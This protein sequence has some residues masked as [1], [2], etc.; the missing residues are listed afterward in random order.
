MDFAPDRHMRIAC[1]GRA[2]E[3][4]HLFEALRLRFAHR[5]G[6]HAGEAEVADGITVHPGLGHTP[7]LRFVRVRT[8]RGWLVLASDAGHTTKRASDPRAPP[9]WSSTW[10]ARWTRSAP[11]GGCR[12]G[13]WAA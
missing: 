3:P 5:P 4:A 9:A 8:R 12:A 13:T 7:G 11:C 2:S 6:L 1:C 10:A